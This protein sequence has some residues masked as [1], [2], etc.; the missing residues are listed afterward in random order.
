MIKADHEMLRDTRFSPQGQ[1]NISGLRPMAWEVW[2]E[3]S[4][5]AKFGGYTPSQAA[6]EWKRKL[7]QLP[8]C[9]HDNDGVAR[10]EGGKLQLYFAKSKEVLTLDVKGRSVEHS[11]EGQKKKFDA[12]DVDMMIRGDA[13]MQYM[14][15][16]KGSEA[17]AANPSGPPSLSSSLSSPLKDSVKASSSWGRPPNTASI[18]GEDVEPSPGK[19]KSPPQGSEGDDLGIAVCRIIRTDMHGASSPLC[20][21]PSSRRH[22]IAPARSSAQ[23]TQWIR[24]SPLSQAG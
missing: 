9:Q 4:S 19:R 24:S 13:E 15:G 1:Q 2:L 12:D 22:S 17:A 23:G 8:N 10:G 5:K 3:A 14:A 20:P 18:L 6:A 21:W 7:A 16:G 11:R